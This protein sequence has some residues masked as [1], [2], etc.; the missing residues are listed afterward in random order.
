[1]TGEYR[2]NYR[3]I[4]S[5]RWKEIQEDPARL[6]EYNDRARRCKMKIHKMK[7]LPQQNT[8][9]KY[10]KPLSLF[11]QTQTTRMMNK[12]LHQNSLKDHQKPLSLLIRTQT[13]NIS[14]DED[15]QETSPAKIPNFAASCTHILTKGVRK[16]KQC[17]FRALDEARKFCRYHKQTPN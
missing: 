16:S 12:G 5:R 11:I 1:M 13:M 10:Q 2:K 3:S 17:R 6:S 15:L 4:V 14:G 9:K 8:T 7:K